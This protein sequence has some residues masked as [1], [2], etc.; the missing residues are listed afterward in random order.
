MS[1][2]FEIQNLIH[3]Y[4]FL[5]D[6]KEPKK[7]ANLWIENGTIELPQRGIK[8]QGHGEIEEFIRG[9]NARFTNATHWFVGFQLVKNILS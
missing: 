1:Q 6:D 5:L 9:L 7:L 3:N 8:K 2:E 4:M